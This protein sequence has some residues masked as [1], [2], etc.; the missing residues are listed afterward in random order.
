MRIILSIIILAV[1]LV[2]SPIAGAQT[3]SAVR[4]VTVIGQAQVQATPDRAQVSA[5]VV[6]QAQGV[7]GLPQCLTK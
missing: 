2:T 1:A 7:S 6:S 4:S 3:D 5:G